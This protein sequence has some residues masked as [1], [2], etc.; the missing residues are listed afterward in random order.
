MNVRVFNPNVRRYA[1]EELSKTYQLNEKEKK[2]LY[3][4][5][6]MQVEHGTFYTTFDVCNRRNGTRIVEI[7]F[8]VVGVNK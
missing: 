6:I 4:E 3:N 5:R 8:A 2:N 7:L 1:K